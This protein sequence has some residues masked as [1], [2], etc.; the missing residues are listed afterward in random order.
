MYTQTDMDL[1]LSLELR[2][3][4]LVSRR[5]LVES[6]LRRLVAIYAS[7]I[8][9]NDSFMCLTYSRG[10]IRFSN[11]EYLYYIDYAHSVL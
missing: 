4:R 8:N 5:Y 2:T 7:L 11:I 1:A 10:F 6:Y 9:I 3:S